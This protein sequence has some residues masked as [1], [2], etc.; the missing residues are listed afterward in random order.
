MIRSF[1]IIA[2][3]VAFAFAGQ[4]KIRVKGKLF[5]PTNANDHKNV[6]IKVYDKDIGP[7]D[8]MGK[9]YFYW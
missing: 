3:L 4:Q 8:K 5:C 2:G 7:D 1:V 6:L 9:V